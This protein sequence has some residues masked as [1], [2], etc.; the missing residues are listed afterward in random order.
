MACAP[1]EP[2]SAFLQTGKDAYCFASQ[3]VRSGW[4]VLMAC[5]AVRPGHR[6][7]PPHISSSCIGAKLRSHWRSQGQPHGTGR[8]RADDAAWRLHYPTVG[9]HQRCAF[10]AGTEGEL[11]AAPQDSQ[12]EFG[13]FE[14]DQG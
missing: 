13:A 4:P 12:Q 14:T 7:L 2:E 1:S 8:W 9:D 6:G 5:S 3:A 10:A 11:I